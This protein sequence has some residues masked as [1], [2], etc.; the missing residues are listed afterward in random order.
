MSFI[1]SLL[2]ALFWVACTFDGRADGVSSAPPCRTDPEVVFAYISKV[3]AGEPLTATQVGTAQ[4]VPPYKYKVTQQ[5]FDAL[6]EAK[7]NRG[8]Q[9]PKL[10]MMQSEVY[11]AWMDAKQVAI[12][13]EEK[14]YDVCAGFGADSL[15]ALAAILGHELTHYYEK[16]NWKAPHSPSG[17]ENT[18]GMVAGAGH[19]SIKQEEQADYLGGFL[20]HAAGFNA[21]GIIP[22]F[23]SKVYEIYELPDQLEGYP[24][25]PERVALAKQSLRRAQELV[26]M[27]ETAGY[28]VALQQYEEAAVFYQAI[29]KE[30]QSREIYNNA[31]VSSVL[32]S[33][34]YFVLP[35]FDLRF[36]YPLEL[37]GQ[38]R[39][40]DIEWG[41]KFVDKCEIV[42]TTCIDYRER[43]LHDAIQLFE[44]AA[45]LDPNYATAVLNKACA[46]EILR[47]YRQ[48]R[49]WAEEASDIA[50]A[51][52]HS[53]VRAEATMLLGIIAAN[54]ADTLAANLYFDTAVSSGC[55]F[56][57]LNRRIFNGESLGNFY[58]HSPVGKTKMIEH[59]L[60]DS[61]PVEK[62]EGVDLKAIKSLTFNSSITIADDPNRNLSAILG[63]KNFDYSSLFAVS[64]RGEE[65]IA[66]LDEVDT[67]ITYSIIGIHITASDYP[68]KTA[69]GIKLGDSKTRVLEQYGQPE[70]MIHL[71]QGDLLIYFT[72]G[73]L[74]Q[75]DMAGRVMR[76][77]VFWEGD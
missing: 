4:Q 55:P 56:A 31:G 39:L 46:Y 65:V 7:G 8:M 73:L 23:L 53:M 59:Q 26:Y 50:A 52:Q 15:N 69:M 21:I 13:L 19:E 43:L 64:Y 20:A 2:I 47:Q 40:A 33:F 61:P 44:Q 45:V 71:T 37:D 48:A 1:R 14:A 34:R 49:Y 42:C 3:K 10:V 36:V 41:K 24:S 74:F 35:E 32:N 11:V 38:S 72:N 68:G 66:F 5:V 28:L 18:L 57:E 63:I 17:A 70:G 22:Q 12:G 58:E 54:E 75:I 67:L 29:L 51:S 60:K 25:L 16:H 27:F 77:V 6:V 62:V 76:W 9:R 30:F